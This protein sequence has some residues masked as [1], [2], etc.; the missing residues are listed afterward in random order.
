MLQYTHGLEIQE[1]MVSLEELMLREEDGMDGEVTD[2]E[3]DEGDKGEDDDMEIT[4]ARPREPK[5][6]IDLY[7]IL[8]VVTQV[9]LLFFPPAILPIP[10]C[11]S[12]D[13]PE[14]A[15]H[16][17]HLPRPTCSSPRSLISSTIRDNS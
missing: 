5:R 14:I 1:D 3:S 7:L 15:A 13:L 4:G 6:A 11:L 10:F 8:L 9:K 16:I 17:S 12:S 2:V